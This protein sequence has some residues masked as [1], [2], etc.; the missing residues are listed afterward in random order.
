MHRIASSKN[1]RRSVSHLLANAECKKERKGSMRLHEDSCLV[2]GHCD[3]RPIEEQP[4]IWSV[5]CG[6]KQSP[7]LLVTHLPFCVQQ[8]HLCSM[9]ES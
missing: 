7:Q 1:A 3:T 2:D 5:L 6:S 8:P 4:P 9:R